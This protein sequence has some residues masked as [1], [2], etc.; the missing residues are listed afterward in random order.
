MYLMLNSPFSTPAVSKDGRFMT[1]SIYVG[2]L[3][4][5]LTDPQDTYLDPSGF[6]KVKIFI[7]ST[8]YLIGDFIGILIF[9]PQNKWKGVLNT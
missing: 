4:T 3:P 5:P 9:H 6:S 7:L 8:Q 1:P 2:Q